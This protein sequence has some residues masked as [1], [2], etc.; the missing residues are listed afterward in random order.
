MERNVS[1]GLSED[2]VWR[3]QRSTYLT[4]SIRVITE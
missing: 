4:D 1:F 3:P 2:E